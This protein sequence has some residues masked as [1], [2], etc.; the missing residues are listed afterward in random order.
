M[1]ENLPQSVNPS[2]NVT[3]AGLLCLI[4][5]FAVSY[6]YL[7][8]RLLEQ[9]TS[10]AETEAKL[11]GLEQDVATLETAKANLQDAKA[12]LE[13][14]GV[15]F[16]LVGTHYPKTENV[17]DLY[18]QM[19]EILGASPTLRSSAYQIGQ[20]VDTGTGQIRVPVTLTAIADYASLKQLLVQLQNN[21]RPLV[22]SQ[23]NLSEAKEVVL[24]AQ[25]RIQ[26]P[27]GSYT[28]SVSGYAPAQVLSDA[29]ANSVT[30]R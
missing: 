3:M 1:A 8:P 30:T 20:P 28:M 13:T 21:I 25:Q 18:L 27:A 23:V 5:A 11:A 4:L 15:D 19:E 7:V 6:F 24:S 17:P 16:T 12:D 9:R 29:Y 2:K 14:K 10:L 22:L 26:L